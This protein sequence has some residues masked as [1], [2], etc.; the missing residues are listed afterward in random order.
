MNWL[1]ANVVV[2]PWLSKTTGAFVFQSRSRLAVG[3]PRS[4]PPAVEAAHAVGKVMILLLRSC[5]DPLK[6]R[7]EWRARP[8]A[9]T[10]HG[11]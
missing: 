11:G 4:H 1:K 3:R 9:C 5:S 6:E 7:K 2:M 10:A 8:S